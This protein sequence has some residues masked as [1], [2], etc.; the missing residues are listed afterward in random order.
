MGRAASHDGKAGM[1][2][3]WMEE[4]CRN[5]RMRFRRWQNMAIYQMRH[6]L[7][8]PLY[9]LLEGGENVVSRYKHTTDLKNIAS[10]KT[11][12]IYIFLQSTPL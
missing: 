10:Y 5:Q 7:L 4:S 3:R 9:P 12:A 6:M 2:E 8:A 1:D 11:Q